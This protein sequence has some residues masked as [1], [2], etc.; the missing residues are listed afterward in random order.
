MKFKNLIADLIYQHC[1]SNKIYINAYAS[2]C[3]SKYS[4]INWGDDINYWFLKNIIKEPLR[5]FNESPVAFRK[6]DVNYLVIG[7]TISLLTKSNSVIWGAGCIDKRPLPSRPR[8]I[9]AVRG[10]L[11]RKYLISQGLECPEIYGDP[12]LLLP[13]YY[14]PK[15][16]TRH[17]V[18][19]IHHVSEKPFHIDGC[20]LI[21]MSGY[22]KWT[23]VIDEIC[24]C[25]IIA[26]SSLHGLIVAEAY[27]IPTIWTES[28]R[29]IGGHFKFIDFFSSLRSNVN[30][31]FK[32]SEKT[33]INDLISRAIPHGGKDFDVNPLISVAPFDIKLK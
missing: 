13:L 14:N 17:K 11:T 10:P 4:N 7:S 26:S 12:A 28:N 27:G 19:L 6:N 30:K 33:D 2:S 3:K 21:S 1:Y 9:R 5:L 16:T 25:E 24:S 20:H 18:G 15:S 31:P 32:I 29:L 23:D 8:Q 22:H